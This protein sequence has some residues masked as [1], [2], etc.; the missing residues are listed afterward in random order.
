MIIGVDFDSTLAKIDEP[1]L[2]RLNSACGTN[3]NSEQWLDWDLSFLRP[4]EKRL[5]FELLTPD[6]YDSVKPYPGA[7]ET[8]RELASRS[9][10]VLKCVTSNP[11][12]NPGEFS[13]AKIR[14]LRRYVPDLATS[15]V[16]SRKKSGLGLQVLVDDGP[17]HFVEADFIP[18]LVE[19]P[20]NRKVSCNLRFKEWADGREILLSLLK[21]TE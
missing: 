18:V 15:V 16:F 8:I 5:F 10:V 4:H 14:W 6:L 13:E 21:A 2:Q 19:R 17:E 3:Y 12:Q 9:G 11:K 7:P 20:W 1:W